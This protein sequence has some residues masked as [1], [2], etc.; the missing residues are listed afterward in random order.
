MDRPEKQ[1]EAACVAKKSHVCLVVED[2]V[3]GKVLRSCT[4][5]VKIGSLFT[6]FSNKNLSFSAPAIFYFHKKVSRIFHF[7]H[8][9]E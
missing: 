1:N 7:E 5:K 6:I 3:V 9:H 8:K 2:V 4:A